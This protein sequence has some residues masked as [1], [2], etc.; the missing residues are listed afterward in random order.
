MNDNINDDA[1][2]NVHKIQE[3]INRLLNTKTNLKRKRKTQAV[4]QKQLFFDIITG[5]VELNRLHYRLIHEFGISIE[6]YYGIA[7]STIEYVLEFFLGRDLVTLIVY[8]LDCLAGEQ[9]EE[10]VYDIDNQPLVIKNIDE[11]W[12]MIIKI[13]PDLIG[14]K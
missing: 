5:I 10:I 2:E 6:S 7:L 13:R 4:F 14:E 11:L 8:Y 9:P 12:A 1:R 3:A